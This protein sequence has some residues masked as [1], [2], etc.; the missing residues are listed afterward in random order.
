MKTSPFLLRTLFSV[1]AIAILSFGCSSSDNEGDGGTVGMAASGGT[2]GTGGGAGSDGAGGSAGALIGPEGG[3]VTGDGGISVTIP[4]GALASETTI[5]TAFVEASRLPALPTG[6]TA[7]GPF[8]ALTPHGTQ[9]ATPVE[10]TLPYTSSSGSLT[11]LRIDDENHVTWEVLTGASFDGG[12]ATVG[13]SRFS[14]LAV[15]ALE[16]TNGTIGAEGGIVTGAG[17]TVIIPPG[18]L[19]EETPIG[20]SVVDGNGLS[21]LPE[22]LVRVG[23][24]ILLA[25]DDT[26]FSHEVMVTIPYTGVDAAKVLELQNEY[27][28]HGWNDIT[29]YSSSE[30]SFQDETV[31]FGLHSFVSIITLAL[32]PC[33]SN[34]DCSSSE[35]CV[36][37]GCDG[38][39][40]CRYPGRCDYNDYSGVCGCDGVTYGNRCDAEEFGGKDYRGTNVA[41]AGRCECDVDSDCQGQ[42]ETCEP[43]HLFAWFY[44][45]PS[46]DASLGCMVDEP[47]GCFPG[48]S[49][50]GSPLPQ[51][52]PDEPVCGCDGVTYDCPMAAQYVGIA[53]YSACE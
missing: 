37:D 25:P 13:L 31:S 41:K 29:P 53:A 4:A 36:K 48:P 45:V 49:D 38:P 2:A 19:Y 20:V 47:Y 16:T 21:P 18:A 39:G 26:Y 30:F 32:Q 33:T 34:D 6:T 43:F 10:V 9:F 35:L 42:F 51:C 12:I 7:A 52:C 15:A 24:F 8:V 23:P 28:P 46:C 5:A 50:P 17:I 14:I 22:G 44:G 40:G 27:E 11:V 3:V 1:L